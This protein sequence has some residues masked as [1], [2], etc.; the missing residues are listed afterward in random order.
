LCGVEIPDTVEGKDY[1]GLLRDEEKIDRDAVLLAGYSPFADWCFARGGREYRGVRTPRYTYV[2]DL[3][4]P[5]LLFDNKHDPFQKRNLIDDPVSKPLMMNLDQ[6]L[7]RELEE[8]GDTFL[9][10]TELLKQWGYQ[11]DHNG[12][13]PY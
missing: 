10:S 9:P 3:S 12:A 5:W 13:I 2:R 7:T 6:R 1:S 4:G 8:R 11:V